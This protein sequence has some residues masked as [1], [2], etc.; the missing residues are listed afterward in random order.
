MNGRGCISMK[1]K[2]IEQSELEENENKRT[3]SEILC[4]GII[5]LR[6]ECNLGY[7]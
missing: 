5:N 1:V 6:R 4:R 2:L 7:T 3:L